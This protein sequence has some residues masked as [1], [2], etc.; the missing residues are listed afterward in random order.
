MESDTLGIV[1]QFG[2]TFE[3]PL[4]ILELHLPG[5]E[6]ENPVI[7]LPIIL[8]LGK[9]MDVVVPYGL[10]VLMMVLRGHFSFSLIPP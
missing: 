8:G 9:K 10:D 4:T 1:P 2:V 6:N 7:Y 5:L 3:C